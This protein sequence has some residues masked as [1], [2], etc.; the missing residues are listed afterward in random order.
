MNVS[1]PV[2]RDFKEPAQ[3]TGRP[4]AEL[5]RQAMEDYHAR[6]LNRSTSLRDRRPISAGGPI[7]PRT[8]EDNLLQEML[9]DTGNGYRFPGLGL[10]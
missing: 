10:L 7:D 6:E 9:H 3:K 2:Y 5:I 4:T 1:E 8:W